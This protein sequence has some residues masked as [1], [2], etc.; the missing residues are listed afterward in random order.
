MFQKIDPELVSSYV[1][2]L[3]TLGFVGG[4]ILE[5]T[6]V[7]PDGTDYGVAFAGLVIVVYGI[8][9]AIYFLLTPSPEET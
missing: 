3:V 6:R 2:F 5:Y 8:G 7:Y 9:A 1:F 4:I